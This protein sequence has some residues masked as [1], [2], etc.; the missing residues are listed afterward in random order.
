MLIGKPIFLSVSLTLS[1]SLSLSLCTLM[2]HVVILDSDFHEPISAV[3]VD[4]VSM[5]ENTDGSTGFP[6]NQV[7][8]LNGLFGLRGKHYCRG[9][10]RFACVICF[11]L[12]MR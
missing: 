3:V 9:F 2:R 12:P 4:S 11:V 10:Y 8:V 1:L 7:A 6:V 5:P